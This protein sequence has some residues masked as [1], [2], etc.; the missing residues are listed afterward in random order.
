MQTKTKCLRHKKTKQRQKTQTLLRY[1]IF[2]ILLLYTIVIYYLL[3]L[4]NKI[5]NLS[6]AFRIMV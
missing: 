3:K 1:T 4:L 2:K 6:N 5:Y